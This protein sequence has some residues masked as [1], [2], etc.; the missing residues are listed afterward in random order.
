[1]IFNFS[2]RNEYK[3]LKM[4]VIHTPLSIAVIAGRT[5]WQSFQKGGS[6]PTPT[7][8]I[9]EDDFKFLNRLFNKYKHLSVAEHIWF[10]VQCEVD[11]EVSTVVRECNYTLI[12][13]DRNEIAFNLRAIFEIYEKDKTFF[14]KVL[15]NSNKLLSNLFYKKDYENVLEKRRYIVKGNNYCEYLYELKSNN[16]S[17]KSFRIKNVSRALLQEFVRHDDL[18]SITVKSTRY[19][20]KELKDEEKFDANNQDDIK[21]AFNYIIATG[22]ESV[23]IASVKALENLRI[24]L[25]NNISNDIAK[26]SMPEQYKTEFVATLPQRNFD[27]FLKLRDSKDALW[28]IQRLAKSIKEIV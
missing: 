1:M 16:F 18:L 21:R 27:N 22:N 19:T 5:A 7:N 8:N 23:D 6:Y 12:S 26:Y 15:E 14:D 3:G 10:I 17:F 28:E 25:C 4:N 2:I 11:K 20:L 24:N 13:E 9:V